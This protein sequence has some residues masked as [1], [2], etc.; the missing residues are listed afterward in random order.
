[1]TPGQTSPVRR[2]SF[3]TDCVY[4]RAKIH[5][6]SRFVTIRRGWFLR[7][8]HEGQAAERPVRQIWVDAFQLAI[9][10]VTR[11]EYVR[12][13]A[14]TAHPRPREWDNPAFGQPDQPAV[15]MSWHDA[16]AY[17]AW[18]SEADGAV[19]L[20]TE[21][22]WERAARGGPD[23][24]RYP[25]GD[26]VPEWVP[27]GGHGPLDGPWRVTLGRP[28]GFGLYGIAANIHE[29]CSNWHDRE[30]YAQSPTVNPTGP[31]AGTRRASRGGA[32]RHAVTINRTAARSSLDPTF[33]YTDYGFR[34]ARDYDSGGAAP[35]TPAAAPRE[36]RVPHSDAAKRALSRARFFF[37]G[38]HAWARP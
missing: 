20:P 26:T 21:A 19:R 14:K 15:G 31:E 25:W 22:E 5:R 1:M 34:L 4:I 16:Q 35:R 37:R 38:R 7:G 12:F 9:H 32:W 27:N 36:P 13:L 8:S 17:C 10:P 30:F 28:N 29:W 3:A 33:R 6:M 23:G 24:R 11:C 18:R 2:F